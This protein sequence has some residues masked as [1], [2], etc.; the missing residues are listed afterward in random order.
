VNSIGDLKQ[1]RG[2]LFTERLINFTII[3]LDIVEALPDSRIATH[4]GTQLA[5]SGSS[6]AP[7]YAEAISA[8]SRRD[9]V[10]KLSVALK[11]LQETYVWLRIIKRRRMISQVEI[12]DTALR[13]CNELIAILV[14][15]INTARRK[16]EKQGAW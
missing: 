3:V 9:F 15:S 2:Y 6:P 13:E 14:S 4:I 11:E 10:H 1:N 12:A 16:L 7:N 5:R 8:E